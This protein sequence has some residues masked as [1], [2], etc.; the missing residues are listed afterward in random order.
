MPS[1]MRSLFKRKNKSPT[2]T[3]AKS[4]DPEGGYGDDRST[5]PMITPIDPPDGGSTASQS[6]NENYLSSSPN[7]PT[8]VGDDA[9]HAPAAMTASQ[10]KTSSDEELNQK[11]ANQ[12]PSSPHSNISHSNPTSTSKH[13]NCQ[14]KSREG[15][16]IITAGGAD[17]FRPSAVSSKQNYA[18][19][20]F[21]SKSKK[22]FGGKERPKVRPSARTSA[23]GGAPRYDWMDIE[24]TAA[25][26]IQAAYRRL[27]TQNR[28]DALNLSTPGMRNRRAQRQARYQ[29]RV[30]HQTSADVPFPFSLCGVGLLF[31]DGT[32][33]DEKIV[34][35]LERKKQE[36][37]K[38]KV[39][40]EDE[41]KRKFRMRK[42]DSRHLEEG[43]E[44]VESFEAE[45]ESGEEEQQESKKGKGRGSRKS[46]MSRNKSGAR[47]RSGALLWSHARKRSIQRSR[48]KSK[49]KF[50][51]REQNE[52]FPLGRNDFSV[53]S[54]VIGRC[55]SN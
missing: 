41:E 31:G 20:G 10:F 36:K 50:L 45:E 42:Q 12:P 47:G 15:V 21:Y 51:M 11:R 18:T 5:P 39:E 25:I 9:D 4:L 22:T 34:D 24:T 48:S 13:T 6:S 38:V 37:K 7:S 55:S 35:G 44:V 28:L 46:R 27:Q 1:R 32:F 29:S 8:S 3:N 23:F 54:T 2:I 30:A 40:R 49:G 53:V 16:P 43:I 14:T 26:K 17:H 52:F 33:E 19:E